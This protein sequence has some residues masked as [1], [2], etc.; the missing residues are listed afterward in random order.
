MDRLY[1]LCLEDQR[2]VLNAIAEDLAEFDEI[3][4]V[5]ECES[6]E[7]AA[8]LLDDID[9]RGDYL[10]VVVSD[11]VMPGQTGVDFLTELKADG[12]FPRTRKI[13]LTG[14][15]THQDTIRAINQAAID[16]YLEK[17]WTKAQLT[18][19][20]R[21]LLTVFVLESGIDYEPI[22]GR[23]DQQVLFDHLRHRAG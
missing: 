1:I 14:L 7:E 13:L 17:P 10:A 21:E 11:H 16:R 19:A 18:Q 9:S 23:L 12:R 2:E 8:A 20:V 3:G 4:I 15:A 6:A 5:E 22:A